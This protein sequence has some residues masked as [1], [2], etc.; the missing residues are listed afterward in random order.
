[1]LYMHLYAN[2]GTGEEY[3][4]TFTDCKVLDEH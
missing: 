2:G 3:C 4:T 1:M